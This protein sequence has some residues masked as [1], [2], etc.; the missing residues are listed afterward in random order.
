MIKEVK[1]K[2]RQGFSFL[3]AGNT[4]NGFESTAGAILK[5]AAQLDSEG[6]YTLLES[7]KDG[8]KDEVVENKRIQA[9]FNEGCS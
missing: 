6:L 9:G 2:A 8:L 3:R 1:D 4:Q 7:N 5:V